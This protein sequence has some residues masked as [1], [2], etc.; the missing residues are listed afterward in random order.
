MSVEETTDATTLVS[1]ITKAEEKLSEKAAE[2]TADEAFIGEPETATIENV[3][4]DDAELD[5]N[6]VVKYVL[7]LPNEKTGT[8]TFS[9]YDWERGRVEDFLEQLHASVDDMESALLHDVPVTYTEMKGWLMFYGREERQLET[10]YTG[11]SS[12][13]KIGERSGFPKAKWPVK[14]ITR[15]PLLVGAIAAGVSWSLAPLFIACIAWVFF[16][17]CAVAWSGMSCPWTKQITVE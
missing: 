17:Y 8:I 16:G 9:E 13:W 7:S 6:S 3:I 10:T 15:S 5:E 14:A 11:T 12:V 1:N 4:I 2:R